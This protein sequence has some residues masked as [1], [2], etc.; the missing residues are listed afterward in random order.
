[1]SGALLVWAVFAPLLGGVAGVLFALLSGRAGS[2]RTRLALEVAALL[3]GS[4]GLLA[5]ACLLLAAN[6]RATLPGLGLELAISPAGTVGGASASVA[7]VLM[8]LFPTRSLDRSTLRATAADLLA[9]GII[10]ALLASALLLTDRVAQVV[11]LFGAALAVA[12]HAG[13]RLPRGEIDEA[14]EVELAPGGQTATLVIGAMKQLGLAVVATLLLVAGALLLARYPLHL[15]NTATLSAGFGLLSVGLAVRSGVMPFSGGPVD[16]VKASP[17]TALAA[18]GAVVPA[19][20]VTGLLMLAPVT[21][22][23]PDLPP[24]GR[25]V[26][27][28]LGALGA[29]LA[30]VRALAA[31]SP[32]E[33]APPPALLIASGAGLQTAWA[34]FGVLSG[35]HS[36]SVGAV[37]LAANLAISVPLLLAANSALPAGK[38]RT[39]AS[40]IG[41]G[42]LLGLPPF[43]GFP[44]ALL[45]GETAASAGGVWLA[46]L[47]T[48][49]LLA[50]LAWGRALPGIASE[51]TT[52][53]AGAAWFACVLVAAQAALVALAMPLAGIL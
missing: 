22:H 38:F 50:A 32:R 7:L 4:A 2:G 24:A 45:V 42:S 36:G 9:A 26:A 13:A 30:G 21:A 46:L 31:T 11:C 49:S 35:A 53:S 14:D 12:W 23:F 3:C 6:E 15:E 10:A 41:A 43:A 19:A 18:L 5:Q 27:L 25:Q 37:L 40:W 52:G 39:A 48:G 34:L 44:G 28:A 17:R 16:L 29:V 33:S 8:L 47:L 20:L 1:M 51:E